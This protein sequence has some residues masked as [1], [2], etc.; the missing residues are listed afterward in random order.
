M[1]PFDAAGQ[2]EEE[3]FRALLVPHRSLG[4]TGFLVLMCMLGGVSFLTGVFFLSLGAWPVFGFFGLDVLLVYIA[5]RL[6]YKSAKAHE[7]VSVSRI[8]L[9]IR[10]VAPSGRSR[11]HE[12]NPFWARFRVAR[13]AEIGITS[14]LVEGQGKAVSIGSFLNPDDRESFASAFQLALA[15]AKGR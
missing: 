15:K 6:N 1:N 3:I 8:L 11:L 13:H 4:R 10:Q 5:F 12:F 7:E 2:N 14:M 9:Q